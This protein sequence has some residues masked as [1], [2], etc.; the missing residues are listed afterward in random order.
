MTFAVY[1]QCSGLEPD[2]VEDAAGSSAEA[3]ALTSDI[4]STDPGATA[5]TA[6]AGSWRWAEAVAAAAEHL[7]DTA[8]AAI[9]AADTG[10]RR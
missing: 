9:D 3:L 1:L 7:G 8:A 2:S 10:R 6:G 5:A 4:G